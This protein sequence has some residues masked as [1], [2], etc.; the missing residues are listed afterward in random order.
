ME[1]TFFGFVVLAFKEVT[2]KL[3]RITVAKGI[4][5]LRVV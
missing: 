5:N 1:V 3:N 2:V 4:D